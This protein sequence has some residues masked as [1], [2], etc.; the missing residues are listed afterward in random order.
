M[1]APFSSRFKLRAIVL[2][3]GPSPST[4][5]KGQQQKASPVPD[6]LTES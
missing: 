5:A 1:A 2:R 6:P 3:Y 4:A